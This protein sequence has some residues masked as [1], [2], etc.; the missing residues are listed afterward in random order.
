MEDFNPDEYSINYSNVAKQKGL[1][2]VTRVLAMDLIENPYL[3]IGDFFKNLSDSSLEELLSLV[4]RD[5]EEAI[6]ETL[7]LSEMLSKAE[8]LTNSLEDMSKNIEMFRVLVAGTSLHRK[9]LIKA[10]FQNM[11]FGSDAGELMLF[12]KINDGH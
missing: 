4:N 11:S 1:S 7:L 9:G 5:D 6:S 10:Y 8:G 2:N 12:E 3:V